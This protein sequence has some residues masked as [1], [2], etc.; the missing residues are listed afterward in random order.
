MQESVRLLWKPD[1]AEAGLRGRAPRRR[2]PLHVQ[3]L[4][5]AL[6]GDAVHGRLLRLRG[7]PD[8]RQLGREQPYAVH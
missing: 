7:V 4:Q 1:P 5:P 3:P 8:G 6:P 2:R